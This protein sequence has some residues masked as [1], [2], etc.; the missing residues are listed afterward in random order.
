VSADSKPLHPLGA[1]GL[2]VFVAGLLAW[3]WLDEWRY[4]V[5]GLLVCL[6]LVVVG[7]AVDG[8]VKR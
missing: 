7:A 3:L 6:V 8:R 2:V 1:L 4:A 5:T